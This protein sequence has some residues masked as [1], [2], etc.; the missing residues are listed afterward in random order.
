MM[1]TALLYRNAMEK[2][3]YIDNCMIPFF[4]GGEKKYVLGNGRQAAVCLE[5]CRSF[6]TEVSGIVLM[7][8]FLDFG[9]RK[10]IWKRLLDETKS[11]PLSAL[12]KTDHISFLLTV[13]KANYESCET[14]LR[15]KGFVRLYRCMWR[16]NQDMRDVCYAVDQSIREEAFDKGI[17]H[18]TSKR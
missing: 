18:D 6:G 2:T 3:P 5:F 16:S 8:P 17:K 9:M 7:E 12:N 14:M 11:I 1:D 4:F 13:G 10:G 15:E